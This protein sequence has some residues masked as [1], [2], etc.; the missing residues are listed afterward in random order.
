M[1]YTLGFEVKLIRFQATACMHSVPSRSRSC[2]SRVTVDYMELALITGCAEFASDEVTRLG[3]KTGKH[4]LG[5]KPS[6]ARG[7][8][9]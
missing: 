6:A 7:G 9:V 8:W 1:G 4:I 2:S 5:I 3:I